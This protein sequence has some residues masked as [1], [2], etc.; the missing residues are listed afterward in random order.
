MCELLLHK[1]DANHV[2]C[3]GLEQIARA[4]HLGGVEDLEITG[5]GRADHVVGGEQQSV[6]LLPIFKSAD[7]QVIVGDHARNLAEYIIYMV[8]GRGIRH[9]E[10]LDDI[11]P[12]TDR[13][14]DITE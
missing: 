2:V 5:A 10:Y 12:A 14:D 4:P 8:Q 6:S 3:P 13:N 9:T 1:R 11:E 7:G